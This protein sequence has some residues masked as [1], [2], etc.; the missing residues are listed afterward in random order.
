MRGVDLAGAL[1]LV[2][3]FADIQTRVADMGFEYQPQPRH[4]IMNSGASVGW[5]SRAGVS[6]IGSGRAN[7][8]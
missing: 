8:N 5:R 6:A 4:T 1:V 2:C 7:F 3:M